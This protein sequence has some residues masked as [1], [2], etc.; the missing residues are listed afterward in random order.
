MIDKSTL[1]TLAT[2]GYLLLEIDSSLYRQCVD[3]TE[4]FFSIPLAD[5]LKLA[6][7]RGK[8]FLGYVSS[9]DEIRDHKLALPAFSGARRREYSSFDFV[10]DPRVFSASGLKCINKWPRQ[11]GFVGQAKKTYGALRR[12]TNQIALGIE[13]LLISQFGNLLPEG[14]LENPTCSMMRL[15]K[16]EERQSDRVSKEHTDYEYLAVLIADQVG[17]EVRNRDGKWRAV[18][19]TSN[20]CILVPGDMMAIAS[21][22]WIPATPH[23][24]T[25]GGSRRLS[26]VCFQGLKYKT[27]IPYPGPRGSALFGEHI[28]GMKVRGT[29]HLEKAWEAGNLKL[30]FDVPKRNPLAPCDLNLDRKPVRRRTRR[31]GRR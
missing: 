7:V 15:L 5:R 27:R 14:C 8:N 13:D 19:S 12:Y 2:D 6:P 1:T 25:F 18:L 29:R 20:S 4:R 24:V 17:L 10:G 9:E 16:Y 11:E 3:L 23:R 21:G 31:N 28:C 22:G 30:S 26:V